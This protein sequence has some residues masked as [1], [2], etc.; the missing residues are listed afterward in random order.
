MLQLF[1]ALLYER[2]VLLLSH[3]VEVLGR[4]AM[5]RTHSVARQCAAAI[6]SHGDC[7]HTSEGYAMLLLPTD[8]PAC[9]NCAN[10]TAYSF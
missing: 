10:H 6:P 2:R 9:A 3:S 5:V 8:S 4:C 1:L 7:E